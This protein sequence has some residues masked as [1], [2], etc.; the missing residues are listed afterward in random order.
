MGKYTSVVDSYKS[1]EEA[2]IHA[3]IANLSVDV[4]YIDAGSLN[5]SNVSEKLSSCKGIVVPGGFGGNYKW[6][7][8]CHKVCSRK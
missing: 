4:K 1:I 8:C 6:K 3:G 2:L 5:D 7:V